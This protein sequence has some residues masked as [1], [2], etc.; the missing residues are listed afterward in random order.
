MWSSHTRHVLIE[1]CRI[2]I[3]H[4]P[5]ATKAHNSVLIE[6]CRIEIALEKGWQGKPPGFNRTL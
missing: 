4:L 3:I 2:E 1:L 6:L 5:Y